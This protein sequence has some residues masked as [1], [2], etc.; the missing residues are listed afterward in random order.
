[1]RDE[2]RRIQSFSIR[3]VA[4]KSHGEFFARAGAGDVAVKMFA[5]NCSRKSGPSGILQFIAVGT[6]SRSPANR[7]RREKSDSFTPRT[8]ANFKSGLRARSIAPIKTS[9]STGGITPT[10]RFA[11]PDS[12]I[13]S[14]SRSGNGSFGK[15]S[16]RFSSQNSFA[17]KRS[18]DV[19]SG[20]CGLRDFDSANAPVFQ[21]LLNFQII[22]KF[23]ENFGQLRAVWLKFYF[24]S[25]AKN[26]QTVA[27]F[28]AQAFAEFIRQRFAPFFAAPA[29]FQRGIFQP[30]N[31]RFVHWTKS[32]LQRG[33]P[34]SCRQSKATV[35]NALRVSSASG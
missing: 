13:G 34:I 4:R 22:P 30:V 23:A 12:K 32:G 15:A 1:M 5:R 7:A 25:C 21:S 10:V 28:F 11:R 18:G 8:S 14:Q 24:A 31:F 6:R 2:R 17:R 16:S 19:T 33:K 3:V 35:R 20:D 27:G 29:E 26:F 9:S